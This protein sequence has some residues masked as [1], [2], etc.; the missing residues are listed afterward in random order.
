MNENMLAAHRNLGVRALVTLPTGARLDLG[1]GDILSFSV[2][3]GADGALLP[4]AALS[5]RLTIELSNEAGSRRDVP[6]MGAT[7]QIFVLCGGEELPCGVY[8]IDSVSAKERS[9]AISLSGSDSVA[10]ELAGAF[11]DGLA[12]PA[13]LQELWEHLVSQTRYQWSGSVPGG[14]AVIAERPEWGKIT[15]RRAAG[16]IAQAA[17]CFVRVGRTGN[18][19]LVS[20]AGGGDHA[21]GPDGYLSLD[22]GFETFGPV[23]GVEISPPGGGGSFTVT[24]GPGEILTVEGNPLLTAEA[25]ARS[26]LAQL[27]GLTLEKASFRWRGDPSVGVGSRIA[28]TDTYGRT[29]KCTVTRQTLR[30]EGGFSAECIC[31]VPERSSGGVARAITPEGGVNADA[32]VGTVDGG[33]LRADSVQARS[34]A[35]GS[36][37]ARELA[38]GSVTADHL[39]ADTV[40]ARTAEFVAAQIEKLTAGSTPRSPTSYSWRRSTS[41]PAAC[42]RTG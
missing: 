12:Y 32:L 41:W 8:I 29:K 10:S 11:E 18:L 2:E 34:I 7:A 5:A 16:W 1:G 36:I 30:F 27:S 22:D 25:T 21:L 24:D 3:E 26:M 33:L 23:A 28:L 15:L 19:E 6:W 4:G 13:A 31:G 37:T 9:G 38:A 14:D 20:C 17:G 39:D 40:S 42:R 35:A